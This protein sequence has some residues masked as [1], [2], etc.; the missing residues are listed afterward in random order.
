MPSHWVVQ[1]Q[2]NQKAA[3]GKGCRSL[4]HPAVLEAAL[5]LDMVLPNSSVKADLEVGD[6]FF[7]RTLNKKGSLVVGSADVSGAQ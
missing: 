4:R 5:F 3:L 6:S 1:L 2:Q 7:E